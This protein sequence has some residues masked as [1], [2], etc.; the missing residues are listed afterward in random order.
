MYL[1]PQ[2]RFFEAFPSLAL[3]LRVVVSV[4]LPVADGLSLDTDIIVKL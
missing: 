3:D 4:R 2:P 1:L